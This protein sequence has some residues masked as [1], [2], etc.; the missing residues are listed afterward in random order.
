MKGDAQEAISAAVM[1][2]AVVGAASISAKLPVVT[3]SLTSAMSAGVGSVSPA[4]SN[5]SSPAAAGTN[6]PG[7]QVELLAKAQPSQMGLVSVVLPPQTSTAGT[8]FVFKLPEEVIPQLTTEVKVTLA[9]GAELPNWLKFNAQTGEFTATAV[10]DRAFPI[11]VSL[12]IGAQLLMVVISEK[13]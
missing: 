9:N 7:V 3:D 11:Q 6:T 12:S 10:P 5:A 2:S 4:S 1:A 13:Q 8:G